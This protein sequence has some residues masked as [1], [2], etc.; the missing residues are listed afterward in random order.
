MIEERVRGILKIMG[1]E[2]DSES[3][4]KYTS[5]EFGKALARIMY[6]TSLARY[7]SEAGEDEYNILK[8]LGLCLTRLQHEN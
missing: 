4:T 6:P 3:T 5:M 7:E 2:L 1:F 8:I